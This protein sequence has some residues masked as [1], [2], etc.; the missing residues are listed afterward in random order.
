MLSDILDIIGEK[1]FKTEAVEQ[2]VKKLLAGLEE[3]AS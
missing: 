3:F 1:S 2:E